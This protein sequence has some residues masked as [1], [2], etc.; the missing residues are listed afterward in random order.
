VHLLIVDDEPEVLNLLVPF[1]RKR[2]YSVS[3]AS[4]GDQALEK[5]LTDLP[6]IV[7]L[8]VNMPGLDGW[9]IAKYV[10][11]REHLNPVRIIMAT[12]IGENLNAVT[13]PLFRA[14]AYLNKPFTLDELEGTIQDV[15]RRLE[16]GEIEV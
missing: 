15:V 10:R 4:D 6:N 1:L 16:S 8:D 7:V 9:Q 3:E 2:G 14:D 13:A 12:G 5:I 11:D